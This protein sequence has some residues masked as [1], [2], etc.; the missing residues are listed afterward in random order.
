MIIEIM[1][2]GLYIAGVIS[3]TG[4]RYLQCFDFFTL[5]MDSQI[6]VLLL[7]SSGLLG[8]C[9]ITFTLHLH[10]FCLQSFTALTYYLIP[11]TKIIT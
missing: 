4:C 10:F 6:H 9:I 1:Y 8:Y 3:V 2:L 11:M 5:N 7:L